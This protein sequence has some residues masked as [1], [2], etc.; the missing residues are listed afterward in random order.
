M[1]ENQVRE[2]V[3]PIERTP[4]GKTIVRMIPDDKDANNNSAGGKLPGF[5][6]PAQT[7]PNPNTN[8]NR[9][10]DTAQ[11]TKDTVSK[12]RGESTNKGT[13]SEQNE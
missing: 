9:E 2:K 3:K 7:K 1:G 5:L 13:K 10:G 11:D 8:K 12:N 4:D 6:K